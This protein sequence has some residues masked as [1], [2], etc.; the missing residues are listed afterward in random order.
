M[1]SDYTQPIRRSCDSLPM[2]VV[3]VMC[4]RVGSFG[5]M[6]QPLGFALLCHHCYHAL[7][8]REGVNRRGRG[9][10]GGGVWDFGD[11]R[12]KEKKLV[13]SIFGGQLFGLQ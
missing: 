7:I 13:V 5:H 6:T 12:Q 10:Q 1:S 2:C 9:G 4:V 11:S 3:E 8:C